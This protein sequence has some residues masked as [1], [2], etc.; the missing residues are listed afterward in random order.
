MTTTDQRQGRDCTLAELLGA[1]ETPVEY[2]PID[3]AAKGAEY[4]RDA[5]RRSAIA[6]FEFWASENPVIADTDWN[7]PQFDANRQAIERVRNWQCATKGLLLTGL[8]GRGKTRSLASLYSRLSHEGV[9]VRWWHSRDLF[10]TLQSHLRFGCDEA[11]GW[12]EAVAGHRVLIIDDFGQE[13]VT[14][15]RKEWASQHFMRLL[16]IRVNKGLPLMLSTNLTAQDMANSAGDGPRIR[17]DPLIRR[18]LDLCD[19]EKFG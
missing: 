14:D 19:V 5:L 4:L 13:A 17:S 11:Q 7:R 8:T 2:P 3:Y 1:C 15:S 10:S 18:L 12:V 6:R 9:D 16:D